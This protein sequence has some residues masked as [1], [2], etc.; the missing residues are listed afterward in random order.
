MRPCFFP[1]E[2]QAV[3][4]IVDTE[5]APGVHTSHT[6]NPYHGQYCIT[7]HHTGTVYGKYCGVES[8]SAGHMLLDASAIAPDLALSKCYRP[9]DRPRQ[10]TI[11]PQCPAGKTGELP[12]RPHSPPSFRRPLPG[13]LSYKPRTLVPG[14]VRFHVP[15]PISHSAKPTTCSEDGQVFRQ[16]SVGLLA[17]G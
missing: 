16:E 10:S 15:L 2:S 13:N 5:T 1:R 8:M 14:S 9:L 11:T 3:L 17:K 4:C 7:A 12:T 6:A